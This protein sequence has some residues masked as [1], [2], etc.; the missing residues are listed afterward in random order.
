MMNVDELKES[1]KGILQEP[2]LSTQVYFVLKDSF[3]KLFLRLADIE[4][5]DALKAIH[6]QNTNYLRNAI[7]D[8]EGLEVKSLSF[9]EDIRNVI[10]EYDISEEYPGELG[11]IKNFDIAD[12]IKID[13]FSF[14]KSSLD[15]IYGYIIYVGTMN[16][17]LTLFKKHYPIFLM[18]RGQIL[19][20]RR[21]S[22]LE[23]FDD[24]EILRLPEKSQLLGIDGKV[25][26]LN[27]DFL[28]RISG[29]T[30]LINKKAEETLKYIQA[31][32]ILEDI[33]VLKDTLMLPAYAR[34]LAVF[35]KKSAIF[36]K[37]LG[38]DQIVAFAKNHLVLSKDLKFTADGLRIRL[39]TERSKKAFIKLMNDDFLESKL[40]NENYEVSAK[41]KIASN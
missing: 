25:L 40:T 23:A 36:R 41:E 22:R 2:G 16:K 12:G 3:G 39:D 24:C 1:V 26:V 31:M 14:K 5:Q 8:V 9:A 4:G 33:E 29:F 7:I 17:G 28:E 30:G 18:K 21:E 20:F 19:F 38:K 27:M 15:S 32:D 37:S 6:K 13:R 34:K 11:L 35:T 10:Y